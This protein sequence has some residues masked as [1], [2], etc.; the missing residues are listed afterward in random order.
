VQSILCFWELNIEKQPCR[1][2][3][4]IGPKV[5]SG[6]LGEP[7]TTMTSIKNAQ[8]KIPEH[9]NTNIWN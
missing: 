5:P 6:K 3:M 7:K 4:A 9:K 8:R 2:S 1:R